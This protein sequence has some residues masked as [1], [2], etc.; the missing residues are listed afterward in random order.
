MCFG[1]RGLRATRR[2][3]VIIK[4]RG[5]RAISLAQ[6]KPAH[7]IEDQCAVRNRVHER[8]KIKYQ[9][10]STK[11][12]RILSLKLQQTLMS[13]NA[14]VPQ[15]RRVVADPRRDHSACCLGFPAPGAAIKIFFL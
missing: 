1:R 8:G 12:A 2:F 4:N 13:S 9:G 11:N 15:R 3:A 5:S 6:R 10:K 14:V 7:L